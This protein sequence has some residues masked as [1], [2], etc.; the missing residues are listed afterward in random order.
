MIWRALDSPSD[1]WE[2]FRSDYFEFLFSSSLQLENT[3][4]RNH[5]AMVVVNL[6]LTCAPQFVITT[7][8]DA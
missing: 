4:L 5:E 2:S 3:R 7:V 8:F 6:V 1:S